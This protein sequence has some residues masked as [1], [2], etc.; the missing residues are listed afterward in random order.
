MST[1]FSVATFLI[2]SIQRVNGQTIPN[3]PL[4]PLFN[5]RISNRTGWSRFEIV[6]VSS[7]HVFCELT[8][9]IL[10]QQ[11]GFSQNKKAVVE[12]FKNVKLP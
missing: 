5:V 8:A 6:S 10:P 9:K 3:I 12:T 1:P 7:P 11:L 2:G 4:F